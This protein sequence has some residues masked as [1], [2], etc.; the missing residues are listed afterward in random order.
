MI[1][2]YFRTSAVRP[3]ST[4][5]YIS[6]YPSSKTLDKS[7]SKYRKYRLLI[8]LLSRAT[9]RAL[10]EYWESL[11]QPDRRTSELLAKMV[12]LCD[13]NM[14][15]SLFFGFDRVKLKASQNRNK[16]KLLKNV[17]TLLV[18]IERYK[19]KQSFSRLQL[20]ASR[21]NS[22]ILNNY[23]EQRGYNFC[24]R[25]H[26]MVKRQ[27]KD[28]LN[29]IAAYAKF[30]KSYSKVR[31]I[32]VIYNRFHRSIKQNVLAKLHRYVN[33]RTSKPQNDK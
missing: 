3:P 17:M 7:N 18:R 10:K 21:T 13:K 5:S 12:T 25:L 11:W 4:Q 28:T 19:L 20:Y 1:N 14:A 26:V 23:F 2:S 6:N 27:K 32:S 22:S 29:S 8:I 31:V 30:V 24:R 9:N 16:D 15:Y 33:S